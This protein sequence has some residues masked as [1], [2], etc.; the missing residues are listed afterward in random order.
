MWIQKLLSRSK[1]Y[2]E[3]APL[4]KTHFSPFKTYRTYVL[5]ADL[6]IPPEDFKYLKATQGIL[7]Y[8][9]VS[10]EKEVPKHKR[11]GISLEGIK[12]K[13]KEISIDPRKLKPNVFYLFSYKDE[14]YVARKSDNNVVEIYEV[15]E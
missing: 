7:G 15:M 5:D 14:K 12:V 6:S 9:S 10:W 8:A 2:S 4:S 13:K 1:D 11:F 3:K